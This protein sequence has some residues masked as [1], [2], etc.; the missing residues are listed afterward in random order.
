MATCR[1]CAEGLLHC[2]GTAVLH[3]S[4]FW[5]CSEAGC[6]LEF[7]L[8]EITVSCREVDPRCCP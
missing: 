2:H 6:V 1:L 8:H 4:E 7:E 5:E 3:V